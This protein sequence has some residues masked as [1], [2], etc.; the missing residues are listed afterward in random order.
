MG[1]VMV[2]GAFGNVGGYVA[3]Y[4]IENGEDVVAE[5]NKTRIL[6]MRNSIE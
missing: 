2:T 5:W 3:K 4:L 1:K 6:F